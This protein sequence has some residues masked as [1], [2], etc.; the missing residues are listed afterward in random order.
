[1]NADA[2]KGLRTEALFVGVRFGEMRF[3]IM[4]IRRRA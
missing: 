3:T 2:A 1:M 4:R